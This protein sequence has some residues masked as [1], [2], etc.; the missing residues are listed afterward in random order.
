MIPDYNCFCDKCFLEDKNCSLCKNHNKL[1]EKKFQKELDDL[2]IIC[3][4]QYPDKKRVLELF[5]GTGSVGKYYNDK[6]YEVISLDFNSKYKADITINILEWDY[7][8]YD[9]DYF[10]IVWASCDCTQYSK[11]KTKGVR[12]IEGANS[13]VL[14]TLE[15]IKYFNPE[16]WFIENPQTGLLKQQ[17]FMKSLPYIDADYCRYGFPYRKRTRFWTNKYCEL[18][19]CDKKCGS[20]INGKHIGSCGNGTS[21]YSDKSYSKEDKYRIPIKLLEDLLS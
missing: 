8:S 4:E 10:D 1:I 16:Y 12:D 6:N 5:K 7:K 17:S 14:K 2:M 15:I 9:K 19:L 21:K 11:A 20:F 3:D 13:L 18:K